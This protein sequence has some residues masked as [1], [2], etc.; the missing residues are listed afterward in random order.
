M[1]WQCQWDPQNLEVKIQHPKLK[2][3]ILK[4]KIPIQLMVWDGGFGLVVWIQGSRNSNHHP[5][6]QFTAISWAQYNGNSLG[7][8]FVQGPQLQRFLSFFCFQIFW[9]IGWGNAS[10]H[11]VIHRKFWPF[12]YI[13]IVWC[14]LQW[15]LSYHF[16]DLPSR[17][18]VWSPNKISRIELYSDLVMTRFFTIGSQSQIC[19]SWTS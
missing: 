14:C 15:W 11:P 3:S 6:H 10:N 9:Y 8:L 2:T 17:V 18:F 1:A 7:E 5:N 4:I 16:I 19:D 13:L 12:D